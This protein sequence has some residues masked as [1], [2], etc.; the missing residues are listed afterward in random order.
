MAA[1][2]NVYHSDQHRGRERGHERL[3]Q[4]L[5]SSSPIWRIFTNPSRTVVTIFV[6][7]TVNRSQS[8]RMQ[9]CSTRTLICCGL[10]PEI[11][12]EIAQTASFRMSNSALLRSR[13]SGGIMLFSMTDW[14]C[15]S[16]PTVIFEIVQHASLRI[17]FLGLERSSNKQG[18]ALLLITYCVCKSLPA[19]MVPIGR[20]AEVWT[21]GLKTAQES[22][23]NTSVMDWESM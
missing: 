11:A 5:L 4:S 3:D 16:F 20:R 17:S 15:S 1:Y 10:H 19:T 8:G 6:S 23:I 13:T 21:A 18:S 14:I 7:T 2:N 22:E 9:P 12:V